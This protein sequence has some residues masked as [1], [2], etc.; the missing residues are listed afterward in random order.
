MKTNKEK[1]YRKRVDLKIPLKQLSTIILKNYD[2]GNFVS[3]RVLYLGYGD[4]NYI[5]VTTYGKYLVKII[6]KETPSSKCQSVVDRF[7][8]PSLDKRIFCPKVFYTKNGKSLLVVNIHNTNYR[9]FVMEYLDGFDLYTLNYKLL[10]NDL[11][12]IAKQ[13]AYINQIKTNVDYIYDPWAIESFERIFK[14]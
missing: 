14:I 4:F 9:L 1:E 7:L 5:L 13:I 3:N 6:N 8:C 11:E 2:I 10:S 12:K